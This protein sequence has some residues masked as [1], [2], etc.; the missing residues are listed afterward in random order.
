MHPTTQARIA[1]LESQLRALECDHPKKEVRY[2][3][4][5]NGARMY[6]FQC[7]RCG[8]LIGNWIPHE[9]VLQK[10][11][12]Q[13]INDA[14]SANYRKSKHDLSHEINRLI[15]ENQKGEFD[16]WYI[17]YLQSPEWLAKRNLVLKRC[18][19]VCEGCG[20]KQAAVV[21]HLT[22]QNVGKEFLF[23]LVGLCRDCHDG[24]HSKFN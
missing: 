15:I 10:E 24:I 1:A 5:S 20:M 11:N 2:R 3:N 14:L 21:H 22:Y 13:P 4:A 19:G 9:N 18:N 12:C 23:E 16:E 17:E 6:K 7:T 8:E